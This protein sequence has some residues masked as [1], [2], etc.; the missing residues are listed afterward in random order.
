[1]GSNQG[2]T[3]TQCH[4]GESALGPPLFAMFTG[5]TGKKLSLSSWKGSG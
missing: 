2:F 3:S 1:M 5:R 4:A